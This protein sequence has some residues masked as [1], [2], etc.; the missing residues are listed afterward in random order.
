MTHLVVFLAPDVFPSGTG[1]HA[2]VLGALLV[3]ETCH[4]LGRRLNPALEAIAQE[5]CLKAR[6]GD[7]HVARILTVVVID[8]ATQVAREAL[9]G[10]LELDVQYLGA[11]EDV[12][13][14]VVGTY[15]KSQVTLAVGA[16]E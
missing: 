10:S 13:V 4:E 9:V 8:K 14:L 15:S 5:G 1:N 3:V 7:A 11:L 6:E 12:A 2:G 16:L